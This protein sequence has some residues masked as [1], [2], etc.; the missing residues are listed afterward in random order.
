MNLERYR[1]P[2][3]RQLAEQQVRFAP[4][5]VRLTQLDRTERFLLELSRE[6]EISYPELFHA[7]T[8]RHT[9]L[10]PNLL[11]TSGDLLHDLRCF[12]EDLSDSVAINVTSLP[13]PALTQEEVAQRFDVSVKTVS[14]WRERGLVGRRVLFG[15]RKRICFL[16]SHVERFLELHPTEISRGTR[17][18][19]V[20][21]LELEGII[22]R[23]RRL[24]RFGATQ[25]DIVHRLAKRFG[26]APE[27]IRYTL[28]KHDAEYPHAAVI[29]NAQQP[30]SDEQR[31]EIYQA[32]KR[33]ASP[34][35]LGRQFDRT[36][37]SIIRIAKEHRAYLLQTQP[38]EF[39]PSPEFETAEAD[40]LILSADVEQEIPFEVQ[41]PVRSDIPGYVAELYAF[42]VLTREQEFRLFRRMNYLKFKAAQLRESLKK[43]RRPVADM[44]EIER[45]LEASLAVKNIIIRCN[46]RLVVS[47]ARKHNRHDGNFF[48]M[49]SDGNMTLIRAIEIFDF[50]RGNKF[51]TYATWALMRNFAKSVPAEGTQLSRFQTGTEELLSLSEDDRGSMIADEGRLAQQREMLE[52]ILDQLN[53]REQEAISLRFALRGHAQPLNLEEIGQRLGVTK[54]RTRQIIASGLDKLRSIAQRESFWDDE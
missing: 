1:H 17:F 5:P 32:M 53:E 40:E 18:R 38:I 12:V 11:L 50:T 54:E 8:G 33:G 35:K 22:R 36:R 42:P 43:T 16:Q 14:R 15:K 25:T 6:A 52:A 30:L 26:R 24:A 4:V 29:P 28:K 48:E 3:L 31:H 13:E 2:A 49:I 10:Y 51:S 19:H 27:T 21:E 39:M 7:V 34:T 47:V 41:E 37:S 46:L 9:E 20:E 45:L 23:A 44:N